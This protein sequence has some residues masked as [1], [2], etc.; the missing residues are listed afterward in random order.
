[1]FEDRPA[2]QLNSAGYAKLYLLD[3]PTEMH[4]S[5]I[6]RER[7][8]LNYHSV[9]TPLAAKHV[10]SVAHLIPIANWNL[11]FGF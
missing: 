6:R 8:S 4:P 7:S 3:I 1:M 5:S 10:A 2:V 11:P 9:G